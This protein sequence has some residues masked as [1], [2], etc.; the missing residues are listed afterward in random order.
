MQILSLVLKL[1]VRQSTIIMRIAINTR[2]LLKDKL[3]GIGWYTHEVV[4]RMVLNHPEHEFIFLF[5]RPYDEAFIFNENVIPVVVYPPA[6][7]P[8]LWWWWFHIAVPRKLKQY[9]AD[10][11]FSPD[12]F[13]ALTSKVPT[14]MVVHDVAFKH[15]PDQVP[16]LVN[17]FYQRFMPK[18]LKKAQK[19]LTVS[20]FVKE[21]ILKY[22]PLDPDKI[23]VVPNGSRL[24]FQ[25]IESTVQEKVKKKYSDGVPYFLYIG[26]V[27]PRKNIDRLLLAFDEFKKRTNAPTK[28]LIGGRLTWQTKKVKTTFEQ[29]Y[30][31]EDVSFLGYLEEDALAEILGSA[32]ALVYIS[33]SEGFGLPVLEAMQSGVPVITSNTTSLREIGLGA[34]I[35]VKPTEV[36]AI[37]YGMKKIYED[38]SYKEFLVQK[39]MERANEYSW[40]KTSERVYQTIKLLKE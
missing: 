22:Y 38:S 2:F 39:G 34:A 24:Q 35:L 15:F 8:I 5:D 9:K 11:F 10:V 21:D 19:V 28:L 23:V 26:S 3:E 36:E 7:H 13:L 40:D 6:R 18:Y 29:M 33:L 30:F 32:L 1:R 14:A 20:N 4:K 16:P 27:H 25:P 37:V 17:W 12:A 31:R